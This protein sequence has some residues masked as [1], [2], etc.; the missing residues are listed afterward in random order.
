M[1]LNEVGGCRDYCHVVLRYLLYGGEWLVSEL[2]GTNSGCCCNHTVRPSRI[3]L[4]HYSI[5]LLL[6]CVAVLTGCTNLQPVEIEHERLQD[7]IRGGSAI[8]E[9]ETVR[10]VTR[11]GVSYQIVVTG[12]EAEKLNGHA[13]G[14]KAGAVII[15]IPIGDIVLLEKQ[16]VD[17]VGTAAGSIGIATIVIA[18]ALIIAPVAI[19]GAIM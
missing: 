14:A 15:E 10:V 8:Q 3:R 2:L 19:L 13:P 18:V 16:R 17:A 6:M 1:I 5:I 4:T 12:V 11:D 7:E 9:G